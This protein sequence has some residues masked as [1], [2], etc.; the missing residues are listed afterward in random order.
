MSQESRKRWGELQ[1]EKT[2]V[3]GPRAPP[4]L[5]HRKGME[6]V[7]AEAE[8]GP[9]LTFSGPHLSS[10]V[11]GPSVLPSLLPPL[12]SMRRASRKD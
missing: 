1:V 11:R 7:W 3:S 9:S 2:E 5:S 4:L 12:P 6:I 8:S 10:E